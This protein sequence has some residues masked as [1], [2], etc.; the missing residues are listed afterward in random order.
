[1]QH[2]VLRGL[3]LIILIMMVASC[4]GT[5]GDESMATTSPLGSSLVQ[6]S[7]LP[8]PP[9]VPKPSADKGVVV[10]KLTADE[11][12]NLLCVTVAT[13][14]RWGKKGSIKT[15]PYNDRNG[16]LYEHPGVNSILIKKEA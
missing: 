14:R 3:A 2:R 5:G 6:R 1:M 12:A 9:P 4:Q 15:Y 16:C 7:V 13:V 8:S 10:G 11:V